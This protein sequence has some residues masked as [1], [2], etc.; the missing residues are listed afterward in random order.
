MGTGATTPDAI[1]HAFVLNGFQWAWA[2]LEGEKVFPDGGFGTKPVAIKSKNIENR[3]ARLAPGWYAVILG[4]GT[5]GETKENHELCRTLLPDMHLPRMGWPHLKALRGCVVGVVQISHSLP[6]D[7]CKSSSWANG[8]PVCNI[9]SHAGWINTPIPCKGNLGACPIKGEVTL[10]AV[11]EAA[12]FSVESGF[13]FKT[14]GERDHPPEKSVKGKRKP[15]TETSTEQLAHLARFL[16]SSRS[17][18]M[19]SGRESPA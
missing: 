1:T 17:P 2:I 14:N 15:C 10:K 13:V 8:A 9:I 6:Y 11:R 16:E 3:K 5:K 19:E 18:C 12:L 4:K 7:S